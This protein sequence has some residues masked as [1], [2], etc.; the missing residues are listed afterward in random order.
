MKKYFK[1]TI[2]DK[3]LGD[4]NQ[5]DNSLTKVKDRIKYVEDVLY[6]DG[7]IHDFFAVYFN[8]YFECSPNQSGT[9]AEDDSVCKLLEILGTYIL[10]ANDI[11]SNRKIEYRFWK[12]KREYRDYKESE[13]VSLNTHIKNKDDEEQE[14]EI[15]DMFV[16]MKNQKNH[17]I[18]KNTDIYQQDIKEIKEIKNLQDVIDYLKSPRG[19]QD[20]R[21]YTLN[22]LQN[23]N[24]K[25]ETRNRLTYIAKNTRRYINAYVKNIKEN[26]VSIKE[27]IKRPIKFKK[28]L[29]DEGAPNKL[30]TVYFSDYITNKNLL[31]MLSEQDITTD[32]GLT[33]YDFNMLIDRMKLSKGQQKIVDLFRRGY[34]Q[35]E[36][37]E[38]LGTSRQNI[39]KQINELAK[40]IAKFYV[41]DL[42]NKSKSRSK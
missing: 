1:G 38:E 29:K 39:N 15:V 18:V 14:V 24:I 3:K 22:L 13:Q 12:S 27:E 2:A 21:E 28:L 34:N 30:D 5:Y 17:K 41:K 8:K 16:D 9:L 31:K 35:K 26:Q 4:F 25:D 6:E 33:I 19:E 36:L 7:F 10:S 11:K 20:I 32:L 23:K 42:Y 40:S 37:A